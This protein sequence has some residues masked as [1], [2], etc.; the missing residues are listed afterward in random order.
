M[1]PVAAAIPV[2]ERGD[3][4]RFD[5]PYQLMAYLGLVPSEHFTG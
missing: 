4:T 5:K 3:T 1:E 2:A